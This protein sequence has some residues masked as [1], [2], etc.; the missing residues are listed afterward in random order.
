M[1][2]DVIKPQL[3]DARKKLN[4]E[5]TERKILRSRLKEE[6]N[7]LKKYR[8]EKNSIEKIRGVLQESAALTQKK[9]EFHISNIVTTAMESLWDNPYE[10]KLEF[11]A[12][13]GK[14]EA[15]LYF[16]RGGNKIHPLDGAGGGT[17]DIASMALRIAAW[18][19][20]KNTRPVIL[21]DEPF[22][23]LS[24]NLSPKAGAMI[25]MLSEKLGLQ[26]IIVSHDEGL[27]EDADSVVEVYRDKLGSH[28]VKEDVR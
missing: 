22:R 17:V 28:I 18:S 16:I 26:F 21:L 3:E 7:S 19:L 8:K 20:N 11:V 10:F 9:I 2:V 27:I 25:K 5:L 24:A 13:R 15:D 14:T 1:V 12:K 6:K 4:E 23:N